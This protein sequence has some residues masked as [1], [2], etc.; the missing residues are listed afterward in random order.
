[1]IRRYPSWIPTEI[2]RGASLRIGLSVGDAAEGAKRSMPM[3]RSSAR[4]VLRKIPG[5]AHRLAYESQIAPLTAS[6]VQKTTFEWPADFTDGVG[7]NM[8]QKVVCLERVAFRT[9]D[10]WKRSAEATDALWRTYPYSS[11][12]TP[13]EDLAHKIP[14]LSDEVETTSLADQSECSTGGSIY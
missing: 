13:M 9:D 5:E 1:M 6:D 4:A 10:T 11:V 14:G 12:M 8:G 7:I 3:G 2:I